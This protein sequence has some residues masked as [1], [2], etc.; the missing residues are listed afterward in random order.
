VQA[1][2]IPLGFEIELPQP[3]YDSSSPCQISVG[4][5]MTSRIFP[6]VQTCA[7]LTPE[8]AHSHIEEGKKIQQTSYTDIRLK[9]K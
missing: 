2:L 4:H 1:K 7:I 5:E 3:A 8:K 9:E 6:P